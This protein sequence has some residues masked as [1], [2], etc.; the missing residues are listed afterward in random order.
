[1]LR[2]EGEFEGRQKVPKNIEEAGLVKVSLDQSACP[3]PLRRIH[4]QGHPLAAL[5]GGAAKSVH[6][7]NGNGGDIGHKRSSPNQGSWVYSSATE[8]KPVTV[9]LQQRK[10]KE[11]GQEMVGI[12]RTTHKK[13]GARISMQPGPVDR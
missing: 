2:Q 10:V 1:V 12:E 4:A 3:I 11:M 13:K 9:R 5:Q 7:G 8:K 6:Q